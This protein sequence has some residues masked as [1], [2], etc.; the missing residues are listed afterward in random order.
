MK[1]F[2]STSFEDERAVCLCFESYDE[3]EDNS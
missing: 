1:R 3:E 2:A